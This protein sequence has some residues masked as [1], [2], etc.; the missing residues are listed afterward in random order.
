M[1]RVKVVLG[2]YKSGR[3]E[4]SLECTNCIQNWDDIV[5]SLNRSN[6]TGVVRSISSEFKFVFDAREKLILY[7]DEFYLNTQ[8]KVNIYRLDERWEYK[9]IFS[10]ILDFATVKYDD[11]SFTIN[12]KDNTLASIVKANKSTKFEIN[13]DSVRASKPFRYDRMNIL[14]RVQW[15]TDDNNEDTNEPYKF[16]LKEDIPCKVGE[17]FIGFKF[18]IPLPLAYMS[19]KTYRQPFEYRDQSGGILRQD[20]IDFSKLDGIINIVKE[21]NLRINTQF[22]CKLKESIGKTSVI[23]GRPGADGSDPYILAQQSLLIDSDVFVN[24]C[25]NI[26]NGQGIYGVYILI[27]ADQYAYHEGDY[28]ELEYYSFNQKYGYYNRGSVVYVEYFGRGKSLDIPCIDLTK[29]LRGIFDEINPELNIECIIDPL[30]KNCILVAGEDMRQLNNPK[31]RTSLN[32][33]I[34]FMEVCFGYT[35]TINGNTIHFGKR[36]NL[37]SESTAKYIKDYNSVE[38]SQDTSLIYSN[39][40]VG[41]NDQDYD[42]TNGRNEFNNTIEYTSG[43]TLTSNTLTLIS[44]YR[45]DCFGFEFKIQELENE[46]K[47]NTFSLE[48]E[49]SEEVDDDIFSIIVDE[50]DTYYTPNRDYKMYVDGIVLSNNKDVGIK[51]LCFT[52]DI[53]GASGLGIFGNYYFTSWYTY[54]DGERDL[55]RFV[56]D[57]VVGRDIVDP[58]NRIGITVPLET[59]IKTYITDDAIITIDWDK[60]IGEFSATGEDIVRYPISYACYYRDIFNF[61]LNPMYCAKR[62]GFIISAS[63]LAI[64]Y[65]SSKT[66]NNVLFTNGQ[67]IVALNTDVIY[68][69]RY[70][71]CNTLSFQTSDTE[72]PSQTDGLIAIN[73]NEKVYKG[74]IVDATQ[75][76]GNNEAGE[77][78]LILR[79]D[80]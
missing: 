70:I 12:S 34:S 17:Q 69:K 1:D 37:F 3:F 67:E 50:K 46:T 43:L 63:T 35:Y 52:K 56:F 23:I 16:I 40:K 49:D 53:K 60:L 61:D 62:N 76:L 57:L 72:L 68:P 65:A 7:Y 22:R 73:I 32:D 51:S 47:D 5:V 11:V 78:S 31:I 8:V 77:Y 28:F 64:K 33:F 27:E 80:S 75:N 66:P 55:A 79:Q 20:E 71:T 29:L 6:Y 18:Y 21:G 45:A 25:A 74:W 26:E 2:F 9:M 30:D 39:I 19:S 13:T 42:D 15:T 59:G 10:G 58:T 24:L 41:Y 38:F 48:D 36:E 4:E 54:D 44:P 14:N